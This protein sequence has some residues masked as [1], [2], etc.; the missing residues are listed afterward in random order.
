[1]GTLVQH[2]E[3]EG[4]V[5]TYQPIGR[6][7]AYE[8]IDTA[9]L[10][11]LA[12]Q[13][14][15][16]VC[17]QPTDNVRAAWRL[18]LDVA[19]GRRAPLSSDEI[20]ETA[21]RLLPRKKDGEDGFSFSIKF[22]AGVDGSEPAI[23]PEDVA[24][25]LHSVLYFAW[26]LYHERYDDAPLGDRLARSVTDLLGRIAFLLREDDTGL[27][28]LRDLEVRCLIHGWTYTRDV[29]PDEVLRHVIASGSLSEAIARARTWRLGSE[30]L[31]F[32]TWTPPPPSPEELA[33]REAQRLAAEAEQRR[34][35]AMSPEER[36]EAERERAA[37][38]LYLTGLSSRDVQ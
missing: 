26:D 13:A 4:A 25:V 16:L 20:F 38:R 36:V 10:L 19:R 5:W 28:R 11:L 9:S 24:D 14:S 22:I 21:D 15:R 1:M 34:W 3:G 17:H 31:P 7:A 2:G 29:V 35:E 27:T 12:V 18:V 23:A 30:P 33:R 37:M 6:A 8:K 32:P